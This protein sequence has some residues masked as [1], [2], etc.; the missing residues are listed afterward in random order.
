MGFFDLFK[1]KDK[2]LTSR[3]QLRTIYESEGYSII[4]VIPSEQES[5]RILSEYK[6][7]PFSK[8]PKDNMEMTSDGLLPGQIVLLWWLN[9]PRT[10]KNNVPQY[11]LFEYGL[12]YYLSK[13]ELEEKGLIEGKKVTDLGKE[14]IKEHNDIIRK[15]KAVKSISPSG[16]IIYQYRDAEETQNSTKSGTKPFI[17]SGDFLKDQAIGLSYEK[18]G[19]YLNAIKAYKSA[20]KIALKDRELGN[21]PPNIFNRLAIIYRKQKNYKSEIAVLKS[22]LEYYPQSSQFKER[23]MKAQLLHDKDRR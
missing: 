5:A 13:A 18:N 8:V 10:N 14:K 21:P 6:T 4:P 2:K 3:I 7:F 20:W 12:D 22:G 11:F 1:N 16:K 15:H 9:N 17:T 19:D 23:L